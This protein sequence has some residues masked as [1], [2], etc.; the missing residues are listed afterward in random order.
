MTASAWEDL[1]MVARVERPHGLR[2][3]VVL[4]A[5]TDFAEER[6]QAGSRVLTRDAAGVRALTVR[7]ARFQRGRPVVGFEGVASIDDAEGLVG[8]ELRIE[9][10]DLLALPPG[11]FYHYD[12]VGCE[13][14]TIEGRAVGRVVKVE[15]AGNASRLVV[16]GPSGEQLVPLAQEICRVIDPAAR[17]IVIAAPD[18]LL[19]LNETKSSRA[20]RRGGRP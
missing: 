12:L 14:E 6:F 1:V 11:M 16:D 20:A 19:G 8:H 3:D 17:R 5:V 13:V 15:G 4:T 9:A 7:T 10:A 2:G 18:G